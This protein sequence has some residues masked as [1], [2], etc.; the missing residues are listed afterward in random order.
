M[1]ADYT[2]GDGKT[3][4][5]I[6]AAIDAIPGNLSGQGLQHVMVYPKAAGYA[7][8][9]NAYTGFSGGG[10]SDYIDI[11]AMVPGIILDV[12]GSQEWSIYTSS[13]Y[14]KFHGFLITGTMSFAGTTYIVGFIGGSTNATNG[15]IYNNIFYNLTHSGSQ[16]IIA[17]YADKKG[18]CIYNNQF[19]SITSTPANHDKVVAIYGAC[20]ATLGDENRIYNNSI[21]LPVGRGIYC[22]DGNYCIASNN[23]VEATSPHAYV[24]FGGTGSSVNNNISSDAT[25]DDWGGDGN[26]VNQAAV[27]C[28]ECVTP[29]KENLDL[30]YTGACYRKGYDCSA[31]FTTDARG[32]S[33]KLW[34]TGALVKRYQAT[35]SIKDQ[36]YSNG[37][38][39]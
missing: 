31:Y 28:F 1:A 35:S 36:I 7:G 25:A 14:T 2:V 11:E 37:V 19:F 38:R 33:I 3:Y 21:V 8:V 15:R 24:G 27:D 9:I 20:H 16:T 5:T 30:R 4:S 29:G 12:S 10:V 26:L 23:Y 39:I 6:P 32:E 34:E 22:G 13:P 18:Y 17:I